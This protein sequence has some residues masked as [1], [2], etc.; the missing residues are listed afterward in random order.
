MNQPETPRADHV[1]EAESHSQVQTT[2]MIV[3][4]M[5]CGH[6]VASVTEEL[7]EVDG[8]LDVRVDNLV[9]GGDTEVFIDT[10]GVLD[11]PAAEAAV[12]EAGYTGRV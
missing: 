12:T 3:S 2:K 11:I 5:T 10:E 4:G 9:K 1:Q 7:K 8:V 6:C